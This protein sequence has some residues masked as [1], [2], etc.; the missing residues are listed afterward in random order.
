M[1]SEER[2]TE[3]ERLRDELADCR[4]AHAERN[5]ALLPDSVHPAV[6]KRHYLAQIV[7]DHERKMDNPVCACSL[8]NLGWHP[9]VG[10]AVDAWIE[11]VIEQTELER[12]A[13]V[14]P[15]NA[16]QFIEAFCELYDLA[17]REVDRSN[18]DQE[19]ER[20]KLSLKI[21]K[22]S[23][24]RHRASVS[25][26][27]S[28]E[29]DRALQSLQDMILQLDAEGDSVRRNQLVS[30]GRI[31]RDTVSPSPSPPQREER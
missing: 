30:I 11:H 14:S 1:S 19:R 24:L 26:S 6:L 28:S 8:V 2:L 9:S 27:V 3:E 7:C 23:E 16:S 25:L 5:R 12:G 31:F 10:E 22:W 29:V 17:L 4:E 18:P 20:R 15:S 13:S 21:D